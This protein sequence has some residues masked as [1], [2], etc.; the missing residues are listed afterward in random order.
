[1]KNFKSRRISGLALVALVLTGMAGGPG[2]VKNTGGPAGPLQI[3]VD[4]AGDE[5]FN[6][7]ATLI[8]GRTEAILVDAQFRLSDARAL[9]ER[10]ASTGR[11]LKAIFITH[12]DD[13]HYLGTAALRERF[14]RAP[15]YMAPA[16]LGEYKR[17]A[18]A[19]LAA[20]RK[21]AP[22]ETPESVPTPES[23]PGPRLLVDGQE[24][25][26]IPDIQGDYP[27]P[28]SNSMVWVPSLRTL[29][30]GDVVFSGIHPWLAGSTPES[31]EAWRRS[32]ERIVSMHPVR[33]V[34]GHRRGPSAGDSLEALSFM[35]AYL[36]AFEELRGS[37]PG[38]EALEI[39]MERRFPGL[40]QEKFLD[41]AAR[42][43]YHR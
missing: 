20:A 24:I 32:V 21:R 30:A 2:S 39:A 26:I 31:R 16:A 6:V 42:S 29:V 23:L 36:T 1:M 34:P 22:E 14:P 8:Y 27:S 4:A 25:V 33:V 10:V 12:A 35:R 40:G 15:I 37:E 3:E 13:D 19:A 9:A 7:A 17:T 43:A 11:N 38:P 41:L 28:A 18:A 5:G